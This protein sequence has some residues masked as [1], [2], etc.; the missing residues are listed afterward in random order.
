LPQLRQ[1]FIAG[2]RPDSAFEAFWNCRSRYTVPVPTNMM[3]TA[4]NAF[5]SQSGFTNDCKTELAVEL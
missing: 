3:M 1:K 5:P 4:T 2:A